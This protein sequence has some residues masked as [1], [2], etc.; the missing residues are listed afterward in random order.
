MICCCC[1][2]T[3]STLRE[4]LCA[5]DVPE[6]RNEMKDIGEQV[7]S[8]EIKMEE[9]NS[10]LCDMLHVFANLLINAVDT[11]M[12][13]KIEERLGECASSNTDSSRSD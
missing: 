4:P 13:R 8:I 11:E 10:A 6:L 2:G 7:K 5:V 3:Q 9:N 1:L 12:E